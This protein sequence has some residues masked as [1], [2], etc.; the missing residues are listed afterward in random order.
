MV[1]L[2]FAPL[3]G[4][5][6]TCF[7]H[8]A[9]IANFRHNVYRGAV[10]GGVDAMLLPRHD[11]VPKPYGLI[12]VCLFF[13]KIIDIIWLF[14]IVSQG[15]NRSSND[16]IS[17]GSDK[18]GRVGLIQHVGAIYSSHRSDQALQSSTSTS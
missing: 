17:E 11:F 1:K 8:Y 15:P 5:S 2:V 4:A 12:R 9:L 10:Y 7:S 18:F 14:G 6:A 3:T 13:H 16:V